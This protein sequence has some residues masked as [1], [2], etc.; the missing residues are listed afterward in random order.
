MGLNNPIDSKLTFS[1]LASFLPHLLTQIRVINQSGYGLSQSNMISYRNQQT[2]YIRFNRIA[3]T[4]SIGGYHS[5]P[6]SCRLNQHLRQPFAIRRQNDNMGTSK[7]FRNI[8]PVPQNQHILTRA[9][10]IQL[11][12]GKT[13]WIARIRI[14][15]QLKNRLDPLSLQQAGGLDE[16]ENALVAQQAS[17]E[18]NYS[19]SDRLRTHFVISNARTRASY[20]HCLLRG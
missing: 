16:L 5:S 17:R 20:Q 8:I 18:G 4:W 11:L 7:D 2:S 15:D 10:N 19:R 12:S 13:G 3:T 14:T 1:K 9:Q 6:T